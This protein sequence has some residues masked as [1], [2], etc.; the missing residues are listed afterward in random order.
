MWSQSRIGITISNEKGRTQGRR[1]QELISDR[2][3]DDQSPC[4]L[5][6]MKRYWRWP[7]MFWCNPGFISFLSFFL[8]GG[9]GGGGGGAAVPVFM[10]HRT[11]LTLVTRPHLKE[12]WVVLIPRY[13]SMFQNPM[14]SDC[15]DLKQKISWASRRLRFVRH[16]SHGMKTSLIVSS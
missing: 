7:R 14:Q 8:E 4:A 11:D 3:T 5:L 2:H 6:T 16:N 13:D 1:E 12:K 9:R 15:W 10:E